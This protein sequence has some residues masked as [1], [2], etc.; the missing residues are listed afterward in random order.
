M[1]YWMEIKKMNKFL[2]E[3]FLVFKLIMMFN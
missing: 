2:I 3:M 1:N